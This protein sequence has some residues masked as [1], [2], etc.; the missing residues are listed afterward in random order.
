MFYS[1]NEGKN[2]PGNGPRPWLVSVPSS[3]LK[4]N[5]HFHLVYS[6]LKRQNPDQITL[7]NEHNAKYCLI[8]ST[9]DETLLKGMSNGCVLVIINDEVIL[10]F[11]E[12]LDWNSFSLRIREK[13][14]ENL[15]SLLQKISGLGVIPF[16]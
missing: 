13:D 11:D 2:S 7:D 6:Q 5:S 4:K 12:L 1:N 3:S 15:I 14:S 9:K 16:L 8:L 10:P